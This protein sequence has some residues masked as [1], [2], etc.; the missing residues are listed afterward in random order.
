MRAPASGSVTQVPVVPA[1][2]S[3]LRMA[4]L[5]A[6][7]AVAS[8][9]IGGASW[10]VRR[11]ASTSVPAFSAIKPMRRLTNTGTASLAAIAPDGRYVVHVDGS[12]DKQGLWM[13]QV[14]TTSSVQIVPPMAGG[15]VGLAFSP[16]GETVL[17]VFASRNA[18]AASLFQVPVLGGP[19]RRLLEDIDTAPAFSPDGTS[20]AFVRSMADGGTVIELANADGTSQ[21][22]L[23]SRAAPDA[24]AQTRVAW[25]PDGTRI[26]AFAGAMP[27]QKSRIV[28]VSVETGEQQEF[29]EARFDEG[30]QLVWLGDGSALVFDA[31][32]Q[33]GGRWNWTSQLWAIAYPSGTLRR[34]T[35]DGAS[36][37]SLAATSEGR[38][39][40]AVRDEVRAGL[41]MAPEGDTA[42]ARPITSTSNGREGATGIDWAPDGRIVYSATTQDNWDIWIAN[43]DGSQPR[44][45]TS[46]PGIE[47]QPQVLPDGTGIIF[48]SRVSGASDVQVRAIDFDGGNPR[49]IA[50]GG[51]IFRGYVQACG[52][53]IYF[54]AIGKGLVAYRVPLA[55]G[56][57][58]PVFVDPTLLPP[59]FVLRRVSSDERWAAGTYAEPNGS[60]IAIVPISGG[61]PARRLPDTYTRGEGFGITWAPGDR[62]L[63]DLVVRDGAT[64]IWRLP[65]D[66]SAPS[67]V[68][69]FRSEHVMNYRWS[70]DGKTLAMSRGT[71]AADV[72]LIA[73]DDR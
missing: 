24:F 53:H 54:N 3:R 16:D 17:Y 55:G 33:Y 48:T 29:S 56:S 36:Y 41:W 10:Y 9:A 28:L 32:E 58:E 27:T 35:R 20:M 73:S 15:Y 61:G 57:R 68:T 63:E 47:N 40:V 65:L 30:G 31:T 7:G 38:A 50:T 70:R 71:R 22:R 42:R 1:A 60:G 37:Q 66:G 64:N 25:S 46:D 19:P 62:A 14:S 5:L 52:D 26:A 69:T 12:F 34:I 13:R 4:W 6:L 21:R 8:L 23:A 39:L 44:Q 2:A 59:R 45:L 43:G 49:P 72:V 51:A 18:A 67:P 11:P